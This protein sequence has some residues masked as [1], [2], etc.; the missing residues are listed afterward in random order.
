MPGA[1]SA[2]ALLTSGA[3][4]GG[5]SGARRGGGVVGLTGDAGPLC[6]EGHVPP[7]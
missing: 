4:V 3:G 2:D 7:A 6:L 1:D 5:G